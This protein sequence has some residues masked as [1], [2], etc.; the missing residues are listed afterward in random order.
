MFRGFI[1]ILVLRVT[2]RFGMSVH[3]L[4][5]VIGSPTSPYNLS[6]VPD[7]IWTNTVTFTVTVK[8]G[9]DHPT[10]EIVAV[11]YN[12]Y[13][14]VETG[15]RRA[16]PQWIPTGLTNL[17]TS[18]PFSVTYTN[19]SPRRYM[20]TVRVHR[21]GEAEHFWQNELFTLASPPSIGGLRR[22]FDGTVDGGASETSGLLP[23]VEF[24]ENLKDWFPLPSGV[25]AGRWFVDSNSQPQQRF[26]RSKIGDGSLFVP[27]TTEK[28]PP[29]VI[30]GF[31][32]SMMIEA[33][34]M[35]ILFGGP[36]FTATFQGREYT[37]SYSY[38]FNW[39]GSNPAVELT[40]TGEQQFK[41]LMQVQFPRGG[42]DTGA[43]QY[44]G[45]LT[46][47]DQSRPVQGRFMAILR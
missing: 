5:N 38:T 29:H 11:N 4:V 39:D 42:Y 13:L 37:G 44:C 17:I 9:H 33:S 3:A 7:T 34:E 36:T 43:S 31:T 8:D 15:V 27:F 14:Y 35:R 32:F 6:R 10:N 16:P 2:L 25:A 26:Y 30:G 18:A 40:G 41:L 21:A 45:V 23:T 19:L 1:V 47:A 46:I 28:P 22:L 12:L 20:L 24:S